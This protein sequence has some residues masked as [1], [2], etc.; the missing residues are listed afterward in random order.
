[1]RIFYALKGR[2]RTLARWLALAV[3][4]AALLLCGCTQTE[5]YKDEKIS[6]SVADSVFFTA[7]GAAGRVERGEDFTVT[8]NMHAGYVP[9]SCDYSEYTLTDAGEGGYVLTLQNIVRPSRV[10]VTSVRVQEEEIIPEKTCKIIYDFNDGSGVTAEE[11]YTLSSHIRPNT[12]VWTGEREGYTL[13]GWNTAADGSGMH[14]GIGSRV[15]VE[16]GGTLTLYAEWAEQLPEDDFLY[17]TLPDGTAELYGYR[18]SGDAEYFTIPS[19]MGGR[20]VTSIASSLTLN[21]PC[22]SLTSRVLV[23]PSGVTSVNG[24]AFE[25]AAFEEMY[26][27]DTLQTVS[28]TAFSQNVGTYHINT[29][30]PPRLQAGNYNARFADNLDIIIE[31]QNSKKLI[32]FSGCSLAYGLCSPLVAEQFKEYTVVNAGLNGEFNALFQLQC[33]LPYITEGDVL[34]HAPEQMNPYQFL[35]SLRVDGRVFAM[36]EGNYDLLANADFS[37][38]DR[39]FA[40]WEMYCN[41]RAD[42]PEGDY[43]QSTG[44]FNYYGDY[45]EERPYDEAAESSRDVTYSQGWGFDMSLLT[46]QNIAALASVYDE[47]TARGAKVYFSWAPVNEQSDGNEDI[48]AAARQFEEELGRLLAPYGYKIIS[49]ATD[50]IWKGRYFYD[51][52]YHL[53]DLGAVLRTEQLIKDLKEAGI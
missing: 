53:N 26:F 36:A 24:A 32:F 25:N 42:Q 41:L 37:Y 8:L 22:G 18:G 51:T 44:M 40:A 48:Y 33:M 20:L 9:V 46:P 5:F 29:A 12:L 28:S 10:T 19:H 43:S 2:L 15:T 50:Y 39:F 11:Q 38:C 17:R 30:T 3:A 21:M 4:A 14:T 34:V 6:V 45:A 47:F 7:E 27:F 52:D 16:D 13:L 35:A 31:A 23:L 49:R 1:M